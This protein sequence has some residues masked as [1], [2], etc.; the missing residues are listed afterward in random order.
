MHY[1]NTIS[2][3]SFE[4]LLATDVI[5]ITIS[6]QTRS[7]QTSCGWI[8]SDGAIAF[9][10]GKLYFDEATNTT[11][12][13]ALLLCIIGSI[14]HYNAIHFTHQCPRRNHPLHIIT[15]SN[16]VITSLDHWKY[17]MLTAS[18]QFYIEQE[19][20]IA[21]KHMLKSSFK[22]FNITLLKNVDKSAQ[23]S[24]TQLFSRSARHAYNAT[25]MCHIT[26]KPL[27]ASHVATIYLNDREVNSD[28]TL[29]LTNAAQ[30]PFQRAFLRDKYKWD[31]NTINLIDW[32][33]HNG[34]LQAY[35]SVKRKTIVQFINRWLPTNAH[36]AVPT[37]LTPLCPTCFLVDETN[38]HFLT[39]NHE[40][41]RIAWKEDIE[42]WYKHSVEIKLEPILAYY[43]LQVL[44]DWNLF[45]TTNEPEFCEGKY[46]KLYREQKRLGWN[47]IFYG[48][49]TH[50]WVDIQNE[51]IT[52]SEP[53]QKNDYSPAGDLDG[54]HIIAATVKFIFDI[55]LK[56]W[57]VRCHH[58]HCK[59][60]ASEER[61]KNAILIQQV[62]QLYEEG[63]T[64]IATKRVYFNALIETIL[65]KPT[66]AIK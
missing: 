30:T 46:Q 26:T 48:R 31:S 55:V 53:Q 1:A 4:Q 66:K 15:K 62:Q 42:E 32:E 51:Y 7:N 47:Q 20:I 54:I 17:G 9:Y 63:S 29:A 5:Y 3:S 36:P 11:P 13:R 6:H 22:N 45:A 23:A 19:N 60:K 58:Q 57:K 16:K 44:K 8:I 34:A 49:L 50:T 61:I 59:C 40:L 38:D 64:L 28:V 37:P 65:Q 24:L 33:V 39:C 18:K 10:S 52:E 25:S 35:R 27:T 12:L 2:T 56:R 21:A 43:I 14:Y 41:Y